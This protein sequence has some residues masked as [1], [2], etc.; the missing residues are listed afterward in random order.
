MQAQRSARRARSLRDAAGV[1]SVEPSGAALHCSCDAGRDAA[2][3]AAR[4]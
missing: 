1:V 2:V 3:E 4:S